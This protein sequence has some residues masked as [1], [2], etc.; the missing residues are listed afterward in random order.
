M[1]FCGVLQAGVRAMGMTM[2]R[3]DGNMQHA[4]ERQAQVQRF[5]TSRTI[6]VFLLTSQVGHALATGMHACIQVVCCSVVL[7]ICAVRTA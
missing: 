7:Y 6:P 1:P 4:H 5:Q 3:I 2:C